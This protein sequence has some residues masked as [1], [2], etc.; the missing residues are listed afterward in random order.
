[1]TTLALWPYSRSVGTWSKTTI[2][3]YRTS[4]P[5]VVPA[6]DTCDTLPVSG[7]PVRSGSVMVAG[8]PTARWATSVSVNMA[9][10]SVS[11]TPPSTM[12][13]VPPGFSALPTVPPTD[14][15][16]PATGA[17]MTVPASFCWAWVSASWALLTCCCAEN[18]GSP[19]LPP[20]LA[21]SP[22]PLPP[23]PP[24][25]PVEV[26]PPERQPPVPPE[27]EP[28]PEPLGWLGEAAGSLWVDGDGLGVGGA[29]DDVDGDGEGETD[30]E[31]DGELVVPST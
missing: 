21:P 5:D 15:T 26:P 1:M 17:V 12:K 27:P 25:P 14:S 23:L 9:V 4:R 10:T 28:P 20:R 3:G 2:T 16:R 7:C 22:P 29:G 18:S 11:L 19:P 24:L 8:W 6:G 31:G 13:P 30:G